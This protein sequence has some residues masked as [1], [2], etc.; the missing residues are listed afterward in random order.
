MS[1]YNEKHLSFEEFYEKDGSSVSI[2]DRNIQCV[3]VEMYKVN[4]GLS[5]FLISYIF[6]QKNS[7]PNNL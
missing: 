5:P 6:K 2:Y 3:A 4:N 7:H 1:N